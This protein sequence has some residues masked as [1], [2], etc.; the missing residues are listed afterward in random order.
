MRIIGTWTVIGLAGLVGV[1]AIATRGHLAPRTTP[2]AS[3]RV[4]ASYPHDPSAFTQGLAIHEGRLLEGTGLYGR[5]SLRRVT[6]ETGEVEALV[7][8]PPAYFGEGITVLG[9]RLYQLPWQNEIG[10]VY[11]V[12]SL[13]ILQTIG[14]AGEGWGLTDD[15]EQLIVSD[16]SAFL[17]FWDP[18]A[19]RPV[20]RVE[21]LD[22]GTPVTRLN[23]L[24]YIGGE[25]WANVWYEDRIARISPRT[26]EVIGWI[27]LS[28]IYADARRGSE[29]VLNGIAY[30]SE[31]QRLFVTGKN[32]PQ[33]FEIEIV[34]P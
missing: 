16:G 31:A 7:P 33:L 15:G 28:G 10:I 25:I 23:E 22:Q 4:V 21:V 17:Q 32:W 11:D 9:D 3:A 8:L 2:I 19:L 26:G 12:D 34:S 18:A 14:Y 30:D 13:K 29:D 1:A 20:R 6:L 27:D 5:S 24:E